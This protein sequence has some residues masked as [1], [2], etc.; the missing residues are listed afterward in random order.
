MGSESM[1][2]RMGKHQ[3]GISSSDQTPAQ[4]GDLFRDRFDCHKM[5]R[6]VESSMAVQLRGE[7]IESN[8]SLYRTRV[9]GKHQA[10]TCG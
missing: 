4:R 7:K 10:C 9:P 5:L 2:K 3:Q 8:D 1:G 6:K